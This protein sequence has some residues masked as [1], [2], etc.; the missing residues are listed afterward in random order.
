MEAEADWDRPDD[1]VE[2]LRVAC[3]NAYTAY[4]A[5]Y[6]ALNR[7]AATEGTPD[8][9][10][11]MPRLGWRTPRLGE[12]RSDPIAPTVFA[13]VEREAGPGFGPAGEPTVEF[14]QQLPWPSGEFLAAANTSSLA[15]VVVVEDEV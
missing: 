12:F 3:R 5:R 6:G 11:G 7:G 4:V 9:D 1:A 13:L 2:R 14:L 10:V 15:G 8:P